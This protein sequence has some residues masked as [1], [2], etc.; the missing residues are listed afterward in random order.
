[1]RKW[2]IWKRRGTR[3]REELQ[4]GLLEE[5]DVVVHEVLP[6]EGVLL[7]QAGQ[8]QLLVDLAFGRL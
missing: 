5:G 2:H 4:Q 1:M 3:G 8:G 7:H 6:V